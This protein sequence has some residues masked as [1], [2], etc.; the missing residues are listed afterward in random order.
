MS[1]SQPALM[2]YL[3]QMHG[4]EPAVARRLP[5]ELDETSLAYTASPPH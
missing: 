2:A 3:K 4:G 1:Q 5:S